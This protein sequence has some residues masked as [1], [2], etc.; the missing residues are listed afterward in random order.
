MYNMMTMQSAFGAWNS[1]ESLEWLM[2]QAKMAQLN[3]G[4]SVLCPVSLLY[5]LSIDILRLVVEFNATL[6]YYIVKLMPFRIQDCP[7]IGRC[8]QTGRLCCLSP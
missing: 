7:M 6:Y 4:H 2:Q 8:E 3:S 1:L 5:V